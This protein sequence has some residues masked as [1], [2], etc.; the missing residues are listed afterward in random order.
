[1]ENFS[2]SNTNIYILKE[3]VKK[4]CEARDWDKFHNPRDLAI[5]I[6]TE[7]VELLNLFRFKSVAE[8]EDLLKNNEKRL[9]IEEEVA[10]VLYFLIRF[11]QKYNFDLTKALIRKLKINEKRYPVEKFKGSNKKYNE[12]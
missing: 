10:D 5:G 9:M 1:M 11:A 8:M 3:Y 6:V 2:D 4:F 12:I 7:S